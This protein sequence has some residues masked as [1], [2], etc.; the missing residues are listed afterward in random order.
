[1]TGRKFLIG[2]N[3]KMNGSKALVDTLV[4]G[5]NN[6]TWNTDEIEVVIAPP[7]P[8]LDLVRSKAKKEVNVSA[9]NIYFEKK[10]AYTGE[11]SSEFLKDLGINWTIIGHSE[12][13]EI[14]KESDEVTAK[15]VAFALAEG[16]SVIACVGEKLEER[17]ANQ[18]TEV[19]SEWT[20]VVVAYEPVW[21]IGTGK[22]A[23]PQQA[24]DVHHEIR[25][26]L[27]ANVS[28][29][30]AQA[31][32]ILYGGSVGAKNSGELQKEV[33]I[34]GF[35]IGGASLTGDFVTIINTRASA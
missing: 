6:A 33:D 35:L 1:M 21:A 22:V 26:W 4:T 17:E 8:Y 25:T 24:Q 10:G 32:R 5:L 2:G 11:N 13:R 19:P 23:T 16:L 34:D 28:A 29:E 18:T 12:R 31:T 7:A 3:W 15:K 9:Q 14:F 20:N 27:A 30:V